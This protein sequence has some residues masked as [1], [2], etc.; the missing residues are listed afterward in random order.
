M[1]KQIVSY[2]VCKCGAITLYFADGTTNSCK[3]KN[4]KNFGVS[5]KSIKKKEEQ[6]WCCNHCANHYGIDI[7]S[8]GSGMETEKCD[9]GCGISMETYGETY[10]GFSQIL[11]NFAR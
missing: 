10:D 2:S 5:L 8:C 4:L 6:T 9:C 1:S 11:K 7:C 3:R